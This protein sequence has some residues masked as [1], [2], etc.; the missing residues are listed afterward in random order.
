[1]F[2]PPRMYD[3]VYVFPVGIVKWNVGLR[4]EHSASV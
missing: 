2:A 4:R 1:V 3:I